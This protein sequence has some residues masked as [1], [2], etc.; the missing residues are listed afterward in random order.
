VIRLNRGNHF[1]SFEAAAVIAQFRPKV[2]AIP[3]YLETCLIDK[4]P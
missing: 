1:A 2:R 3:Q 4:L